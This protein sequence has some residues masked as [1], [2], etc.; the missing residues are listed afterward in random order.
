VVSH[1][2][3]L[4]HD[5]LLRQRQRERRVTDRGDAAPAEVVLDSG[6]TG[7]R[8]TRRGGTGHGLG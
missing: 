2:V 6:G 5:A 7:R 3:V 4:G 1:G 8:G